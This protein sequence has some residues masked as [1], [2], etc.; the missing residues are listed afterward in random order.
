MARAAGAAA[1]VAIDTRQADL[2]RDPHVVTAGAWDLALCFHYLDRPL[3]GITVPG[4]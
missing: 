3:C 4:D 1:G 2:E